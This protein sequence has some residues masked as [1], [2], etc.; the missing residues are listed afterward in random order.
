MLIFACFKA[1]AGH[2]ITTL[3]DTVKKTLPDGQY[4]AD[5]SYY[6]Y[7]TSTSAD[8]NLKIKV[9]DGLVTVIH[10]N[11]GGIIHN[12]INNENYLYTGGKI[13]AEINKKSGKISYSTQVSISNGNNISTYRL[14]ISKN[15]PDD[16]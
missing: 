11:N 5:V 2:H 6:N 4:Y 8:Y 1:H 12:G 3:T 9:K 14:T 7:A 13:E 15:T 16:E 10:L